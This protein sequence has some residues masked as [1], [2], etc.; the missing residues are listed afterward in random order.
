MEF[1]FTKMHGIGNDYIYFDG[2][3]QNIPNNAEFIQNISDRHKGIGAD[4]M[5]V[6]LS[7][8]EYDFKMK[9]FNMDGS[10][11]D[12]CGNGIRCFAKFCYDKKL[13]DKKILDIETNAGVKKIELVFDKEEVTGAIVNMGAPILTPSL[14]PVDINKEKLVDEPIIINNKEYRFTGISMGNP[15][16]VV[17]VDDL[18]VDINEIGPLFENNKIFPKRI[19]TEFVQVIDDS[20]VKMRVWERGSGET[21]A[22]GTGACA[23]A[24]A[25]YLLGKTK[26]K[27]TV[28]LLG[29][30]LDIEY[31]NN[32]IY[33]QGSATTVFEGVYKEEREK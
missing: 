14:I 8:K 6:I 2:I 16:A 4:G 22:C 10:E 29:G 26:N 11:G 30:N 9:M 25:S 15:H 21:Q 27:V 20:V 18:N 19:N 12:M 23:A 7:S 28:Q 1:K 33:M 31:K 13:T 32:V 5:I 17:F 3:N 24:Y